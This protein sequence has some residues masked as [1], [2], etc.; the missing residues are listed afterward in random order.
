MAR[1]RNP[2]FDVVLTVEREVRVKV[3]AADHSR[4]AAIAEGMLR[5]PEAKTVTVSGTYAVRVDEFQRQESPQRITKS[6]VSTET[7][8]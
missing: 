3:R 5:S 7:A 2:E 8:R 4:A 1:K 6:A